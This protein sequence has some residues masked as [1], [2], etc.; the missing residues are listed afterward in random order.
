MTTS[1]KL[2]FGFATLILVLVLSSL[3][4][5]VRVWSIEG[6]ARAL[7]DAR[8]VSAAAKELEINVLGYALAVRTYVRTGDPKAKEEA[9]AESADV[10]RY[11]AEYEKL[12][13]S[14]YT[15][16]MA[17]RFALMWQ[18]FKNIG[19]TLIDAENRQPAAAD[20][21]RFYELRV[22]LDKL[23]DDEIQPA[24]AGTYE[25]YRDQT[26]NN[27]GR[28]VFFVALLL[29]TGAV[30]AL[31]TSWLVGR[32]VVATEKRVRKSRELLRVTLASIGDAVITTDT[33]GRVTYLNAV[34]EALTGWTNEEAAGQP[35]E[36]TFKI[37][38]ETSRETV[39]N[40]A[41]KALREGT[42]VGL[43]NHTILIAKDGTEIPIDD[44]ASPIRDEKGTV[45]GAVLIFRDFTE[46]RK[47][48]NA[49]RDS[50]EFS[51]SVIE[52][53]P[54][55]VKVLD[56][57]GRLLSMNVNGTC[58]MEI[59]DFASVEG[60]YWSDLWPEERRGAVLAAIET[61]RAGGTGIFQGYSPTYKGTPK[62]WEV[63][64]APILDANG[65]V[66]RFV[67]MSRD[68][69]DRKLVEDELERAHKDLERRV[70]ERTLEITYTNQFL[71]ALLENLQEGIVACD[72]E[73]VLTLFN[74]ATRE[75]HGLPEVPIPAE[76]WADHYD[77]FQAD[78]STRMSKDEIPLFRALAGEQVKG[79]EMVIARKNGQ[80]STL[81]ASGQAFHDEYGK[82]LGAVVS[83]HDITRRKQAEEGLRAAYDDLEI[84]V[85]QRTAELA[86]SEERFR[87]AVG[88]VSSLIW[89]NDEKG[90]MQGAQPGWESFTGQTF[91]EYQ[92]YGWAKAV[93]PDDAQPTIEEWE[94]AVAG[95]RTFEFEHRVRRAD[96][97]W[98]LCSIRAVPIFGTDREIREWVGVHND[99]TEHR[100]AEN[101]LRES[102]ARF[103]N[104][105]DDA[106]VMIWVTEPD[107][108]CTY[109]SASWY[110]FTGQ[111][112]ESGMGMGWV[113]AVHPD[114]QKMANDA[115]VAAN[116]IAGT[117]RVEYRLR[118]KDGEYRW[119]IDAATPRISPD[120][121]FLGYIGSV[122]DIDDRK[123]VEQML[124]D[125]EKRFREL[126]ETMPQIVWTARPDGVLNYYNRRWFEYIDVHPDLIE[127]AQWDKYIHPG[128]LQG[129]YDAWLKSI[130][131]GLPYEIEFR[132][133][134][135]DGQYRWFLVR[136]LPVRNDEGRIDQWFGTCTDIHEQKEMANE[137]RKLAANLSE[138]D[139]RKNEFLAMLAHELRNPLAP[140]SNAL[141]II[142][143]TN[144]GAATAATEMMERQVGQL[145]RLVDDLLDVSRITQG[146]IELRRERIELASVVH[147]AVEAARPSCEKGGVELT[148][149]M[150]AEP[151]YLNGDQIRLAQVIGNLLNNSCKFTDKGGDIHLT[152]GLEEEH[153]L[154][155]VR[156]TGLGIAPDQIRH[157]FE[158]FVQADTSLE[159][160]MSG[161]GIGLTLVKNLVEMHDGMIEAK[162][163]GLGRGSEFTV[164]LPVLNETEVISLVPDMTINEKA[165]EGRRILVVDDNMDSAESLSMLL[166]MTGNDVR[167]AHDGREAVDTAADFLPQV[168]LLDIGLPVLN[169]YEAAREIRRQPW[170]EN[171][172]LIALTGWGQDEDRKR[173]KDAGFD[174]HMVKP[175]DHGALMK[176]LDELSGTVV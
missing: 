149:D 123:A 159:R 5:I 97:E 93:H 100:N 122:V 121:R 101:Q 108:S 105:A 54:D 60:K 89:T 170:G 51:R 156:D 127:D 96:G 15:R 19:Q 71:N 91:E 117:F 139:H 77:L 87:A 13:T 165:G 63:F 11:L 30:I 164:R 111:T 171:M 34:A 125:S 92:G 144:D 133:K 115:F 104:M 18:E 14:D 131:T 8:N 118:G 150:Q 17:S 23:L 120:G 41:A 9:I 135:A 37:V 36:S 32:G 72:A 154:I 69:T 81:L 136:A 61:A 82:I 46:R 152:V 24:A 128:D 22:G 114:E 175:V 20:S 102:E 86:A 78:G 10:D 50:E 167:M 64:V 126:A 1:K 29:I 25:T 4:I 31:I 151:I 158:L 55:C 21:D 143:L 141:Q 134:R 119:F 76:Q 138:A 130:D 157:I 47:A 33:E 148:V 7:A 174:S 26:L 74:R 65:K 43:A 85:A 67:S 28:I 166:K 44:S 2:W 147:H 132:V 70:T 160:S 52:S 124:S 35:L 169:G 129:A 173:S 163:E 16:Q 168:I 162:S 110:A 109:L 142:R 59:D 146:K 140:I 99:I 79:T 155:R 106:P 80:P 172:I 66:E 12:G 95:K 176:R 56:A 137:L 98:R 103:R 90:E 48:E 113:N 153:A 58:L 27:T 161:L 42:I 73:G 116:E 62:W 53:S 68:I 39:E 88:A 40:P 83:M 45:N 3:A 57:E 75:L 49:L 6:D 38:N 94:K 107:G 112:P 84:R 145:V